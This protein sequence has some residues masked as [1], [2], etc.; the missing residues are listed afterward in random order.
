MNKKTFFS[1]GIIAS[2]A[3]LFSL[4]WFLE[5]PRPEIQIA[6]SIVFDSSTAEA[7]QEVDRSAEFAL[8]LENF[9]SNLPSYDDAIFIDNDT[10]AL[11]A[12]TDGRIWQVN[13]SSHDAKPFVDVP[14]MAFGIDRDPSDSNSV[15]FCA[16]NSYGA[17]YPPGE[18]AG[19]YRLTLDTRKIEPIVL[20]V[21]DTEIDPDNPV[22]YADS[23]PNAPEL[24]SDGSGWTSRPLAVCDNL[25][26]TED[27]R[28][29]Y[30]SEPFA[31][32]NATPDDAIDEAIALS[33]NGRLWRYDLGT[34]TTRLIAEGFHF[35]NGVLYDLHPDQPREESVLVTQTSLFRLTRFYLRG[36]KAGSAE[37]VLDGITGMDDGMDRDS[38]G[39]IW[40]ALFLERTPILTWVHANAW[41]KPLLMRLPTGLLPQPTRTGVL[42]VSPDGSK[43]LYAAI[44]EGSL[45]SSIASAVP[46][47]EGIYLANEEIGGSENPQ[48]K[49]IVR[50]KWPE[51]LV[52]K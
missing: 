6:K 47:P 38:E 39:R 32:E 31:Y 16:S 26:V 18:V 22:I 44:Y 25:E 45:L 5:A 2:L 3:L 36:S 49:D 12:A 10:K 11:I 17:E 24:Q 50:L 20:E 40:L 21:P 29:I 9:Q 34:K 23:D 46:S 7:I 15:Y 43:P 48:K 1:I 42:V 8:N 19:L 30:F 4:W 35:I 33:P 14:L 51:Y 13:L 41:I 37:V 28:R 52:Q 27:G